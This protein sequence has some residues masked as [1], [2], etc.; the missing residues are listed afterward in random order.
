V[1]NAVQVTYKSEN[2]PKSWRKDD[3]CAL[4]LHRF[5]TNGTLFETLYITFLDIQMLAFDLA[6][7]SFSEGENQGDRLTTT[8]RYRQNRVL[9]LSFFASKRDL[10]PQNGQL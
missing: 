1:R 10:N 3:L 7:C 2:A 8:A 4:F 6:G 5:S 9:V